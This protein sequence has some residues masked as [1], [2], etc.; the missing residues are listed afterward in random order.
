L[1]PF[2]L[3]LADGRKLPSQDWSPQLA[4]QYD[5]LR[6]LAAALQQRSQEVEAVVVAMA[7]Y[8]PKPGEAKGPTAHNLVCT[9][10]SVC[11]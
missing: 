8:Q 2:V 7:K 1:P 9:Q 6:R 4:Q 11:I 5:Y 3:C 10:V